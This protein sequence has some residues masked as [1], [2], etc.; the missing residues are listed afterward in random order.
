MAGLSSTLMGLV[1]TALN[2]APIIGALFSAMFTHC[3]CLTLGSW[4]GGQHALRVVQ[5]PVELV[6]IKV[7]LGNEA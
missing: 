6:G 7:F 5:D 1:K 3:E 2:K 4:Q